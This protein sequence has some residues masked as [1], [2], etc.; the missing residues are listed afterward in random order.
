M[1]PFRRLSL[2]LLPV[3]FLA[4]CA[5]NPVTGRSELA[6]VSVSAEEEVGIGQK[7]FPQ[8]VQQMGGEYPDPALQRYVEQVGSGLA[9]VSERPELPWQFRVVNDSSPN[10]FALPGGHIAITRGLLVNLGSEAELAAVLG[11]EVAHVTAR[12]AVA[13]L[14]RGSL[15]NLGLTVLAGATQGASYGVLAQQAGALAAELLDKRYSRDQERESDRLGIDYMVKAGYDPRGAV[16]L[17][18]FFHRQLEGGS[19]GGW[20]EGMFRSHPF[21]VERLAANRGYIEQRYPATAAEQ[22]RLR[23]KAFLAAT[24]RLRGLKE[25]YAHF[26]EARGLERR[27]ELRAAVAA[28]LRAAAAGPDETAILTGLGMA[29]LRSEDLAAA[30]L[31]LARAVKLDGR[32]YLPRL[33]LGYVHLQQGDVVPATAELE[34][35]QRLLPTQQ[36]ALLLGEA[37]EK[38]KRREAAI[39]QY[40][41]VVAADPDGKNGRLAADRLRML[42]VTQ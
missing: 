3:S 24:E 13:G 38:A 33:G 18:E 17:Q 11:H 31:H 12:H 36:G 15:L 16:Q 25:A 41:A 4:A 2:L 22:E 20:L 21:S 30:R 34:A 26:D 40:R 19:R 8:A 10:A 37:Y 5:T 29:Y 1:S 35:S 9:R 14:Q 7:T 39:E 6:L 32:H 27:G 28:Y 42:G 23:A